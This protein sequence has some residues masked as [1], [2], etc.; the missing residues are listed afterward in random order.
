VGR[1]HRL[2]GSV[3]HPSK[4]AGDESH[5]HER[6]QLHLELH[7]VVSNAAVVIVPLPR[8]TW[9]LAFR[10]LQL[11]ASAARS[12]WLCPSPW[13]LVP[14]SSAAA[15]PAVPL[16]AHRSRFTEYR[17]TGGGSQCLYSSASYPRAPEALPVP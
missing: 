9:K 8:L 2:S 5:I 6:L 7:A 17:S 12:A 15:L 1:R 11:F 16:P 10:C 14:L 13:T 3:S 4:G